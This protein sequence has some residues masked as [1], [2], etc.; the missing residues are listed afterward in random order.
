MKKLLTILLAGHLAFLFCGFI[1]PYDEADQNRAASYAPPTKV[2]FALKS[3]PHLF[4]CAWKGRQDAQGYT[5]DC[6]ETYALHFFASRPQSHFFGV[7]APGRI[8]LFGTDGLGRDQFSRFLFGARLSLF[9][10]LLATTFALL[11][12]VFIGTLAGFYGSFVD[13]VLMRTT[14]LFLALPWIY[15][16]L[17]VRAFLPLHLSPGQTFLL[18]ITIIGAIGW[19]RPARL[20]R[21]IVL[22]GKQRNFVLAA[23]N[24]GATD[25][26]LLR[27]H[28][29]PQVY[30]VVLAQAALLVPQYVLAE[31]TLSFLGLGVGEP[32]ASLGNLLA[33]LQQYHVLVSYWWMFLPGIGLIPI[34]LA[35]FGVANALQRRLKF[36]PV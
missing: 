27:N 12:G 33:V 34:F 19:A 6:N 7:D 29:L 31:I 35:Y 26:Y 9:A 30:G 10:G 21:G 32:A 24:L 15:L 2:H 23:R 11:I 16:L 22:S 5:E 14:E 17:G 28:I 18:L 36:I 1:A 13:T 4:V 3:Q 8:S 20:V 25:A